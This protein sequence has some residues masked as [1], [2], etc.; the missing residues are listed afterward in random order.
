MYILEI[1]LS[2]EEHL[3]TFLLQSFIGW[4]W[5][6]S[7]IC[8]YRWLPIQKTKSVN[9]EVSQIG[10]W[11]RCINQRVHTFLD[12]GAMWPGSRCELTRLQSRRVIVLCYVPCRPMGRCLISVDHVAEDGRDYHFLWL[13]CAT[14]H[15]N[16]RDND[17]ILFGLLSY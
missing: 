16:F 2:H 5:L 17:P 6:G 11:W 8:R 15:A 12:D 1:F 4:H 13:V 10:C 14:P 7:F 9:R 3:C